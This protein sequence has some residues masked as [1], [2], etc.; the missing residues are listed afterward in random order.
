[1]TSDTL[2]SSEAGYPSTRARSLDY[3]IGGRLAVFRAR[4][5]FTRGELAARTGVAEGDLL[6]FELGL[7]EIP[8]P[9]IYTLSRVLG[10]PMRLFF[11]ANRGTAQ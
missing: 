5:A 3:I 2:P 8:A 6:D 11:E 10:V 9:I 1:M 4:Q 7:R